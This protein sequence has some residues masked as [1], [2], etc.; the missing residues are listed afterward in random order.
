MYSAHSTILVIEDQAAEALVL[1]EFLA[2]FGHATETAGDGFEGLA[3]ARLGV[4]LVLVDASMPGMDGFEVIR[5]LRADEATAALPV[6]MVTAEGSREARLRAL[7][8]GADDFIEKPVTAAELRLRVATQLALSAARAAER[9]RL[10]ELSRLVDE[11]T[12]TLR[13]ALTEMADQQRRAEAA[14]LETVRLLALAAECKDSTTANHIER[15]SRYCGLLGAAVGLDAEQTNLLRVASTLHDVGKLAVPDAALA[16]GLPQARRHTVCGE[17]LLRSA[18]SP[19]LQAAAT[20]ARHHHEQWDGEGHPDGL[21][22]EDI[23]L[24]ARITA[25]ADVFD[26]LTSGREDGPSSTAEAFAYLRAEAGR[27]FDP[28][29]VERF[30]ELEG[31]VVAVQAEW[32]WT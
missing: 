17:A 21:A 10:D 9:A 30:G 28:T 4:A 31:A 18:T 27:L 29:L 1:T 5:R 14:H 11:K 8:A 23:P 7:E 32:P 22:G 12:R 20:I 3:R 15:V 2:T 16:D 26:V 19:Y 24:F 13:S 6:I 25:I